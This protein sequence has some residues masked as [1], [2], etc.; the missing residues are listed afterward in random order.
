MRTSTRLTTVLA[1]SAGALLGSACGSDSTSNPDAR[2]S[3]AM[4]AP[5]GMPDA[6][7]PTSATTIAVTQVA[8]ATA[9]ATDFG[10]AGISISFD[11]LLT[12]GKAPDFGSDAPGNCAVRRWTVGTPPAPSPTT[13]EGVVQILND[14]G[15][16]GFDAVLKPVGNCGFSAMDSKYHCVTAVA[17]AAA[18]TAT[19]VGSSGATYKITG[20]TFV[21][22]DVVGQYLQISGV[23]TTVV[24]ASHTIN[25]DGA[26]PI[27][28][29][30]GTD[31]LIVAN[32][33][34]TSG[35][36]KT[37]AAASYALLQGEGPIPH[38]AP[39]GASEDKFLTDAVLNDG[40]NPDLPTQ[41][42]EVKIAPST[43]WPS[44]F[45]VKGL[46][47]IGAGFTLSD[48]QPTAFPA[49]ATADVPVTCAGTCGVAP[50]GTALDG[51]VVTGRTTTGNVN[52]A[53]VAPFDMPAPLPGTSYA[54]FTCTAILGH[55]L[56]IPK[57]ALAV[58]LQGNPTRV[59]T[60]VI[61][62]T[63]KQVAD[64]LNTGNVLTGHTL[65]GHTTFNSA[66]K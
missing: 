10:G 4:A 13:D 8:V 34:A 24:D 41:T 17:A 12:G 25:Y 65:V 22:K 20:A 52:A 38:G 9:G 28:D 26:F 6:N 1:F 19:S 35:D 61:R 49:V 36:A 21:K 55:S 14:A 62:A 7:V 2:R 50:V 46:Q 32:R 43:R 51:F 39:G 44:G 57:E 3:D 60:R 11:D 53:G 29:M 40:K 42:L 5:D 64:G 45:D 54:T 31:T 66:A 33:T 58:I 56:T 15:K 27:I 59:E 47:P 30:I 37:F 63:F 48:F 18:G 16:A 23:G